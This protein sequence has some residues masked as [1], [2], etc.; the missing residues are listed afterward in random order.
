MDLCW[1]S[2]IS[3]FWYA[4]SVGQGFSSKEQASFSFMT[5]VIICSDFGSQENKVSHCF[6]CF[7]IYFSWS[8]GTG[9]HGLSLPMLNFKPTFS[10][11]FLTFIKRLLSSLLSIIRVVP[12]AYLR[13]LIFLQAVFIPACDSLSLAFCMMYSACKLNKQGDNMQPGYTPFLSWN[14]SVVLCPVLTVASWPAYIFL[15]RQV[16][17]SGMPI[18]LRIFHI[19]MGTIKDRNGMDLTEAQTE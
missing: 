10:L 19:K 17:W 13:L 2:N 6:H 7:P 18:S 5:A 12:S 15:R 9:C 8:N 3:A 1:Q 11:S 14:H 16:M 4:V